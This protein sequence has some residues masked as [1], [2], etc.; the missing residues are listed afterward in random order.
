MC[1]PSCE[2]SCFRSAIV[3]L[4]KT[5]CESVPLLLNCASRDCA[6][7]S[8]ASATASCW[9]NDDSRSELIEAFCPRTMPWSLR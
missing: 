9:F 1:E 6:S 3:R 5:S 4:F 7:A 8:A 2:E